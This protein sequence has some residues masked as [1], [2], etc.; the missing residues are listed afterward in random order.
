MPTERSNRC[1]A[2][3]G[4][5]TCAAKSVAS[6]SALPW[7]QCAQQRA[8]GRNAGS[9]SAWG[10]GQWYVMT[11]HWLWNCAFSRAML[12]PVCRASVMG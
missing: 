3:M 10:I 6:V 12:R 9:R 1:T 4:R 11:F 7:Y 2:A 5:A 8:Q